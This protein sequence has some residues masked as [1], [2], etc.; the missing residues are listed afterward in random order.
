[1][2]LTPG[3]FVAQV[4]GALLAK[5]VKA[6]KDPGRVNLFRDEAKAPSH[7]VIQRM[8][9][10]PYDVDVPFVELDQPRAVRVM[11]KQHIGAPC[12]PLVGNGDMVTAGQMIGNVAEGALGAPVHASIS[13]KVVAV[14]GE[15][16]DIM[17][18]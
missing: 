18:A 1:M 8:G 9:L 12:T 16:V 10:T 3:R 6:T 17:K 15:Y 11:L 7:R 5:K 4:R 14:T 13:G 2:G